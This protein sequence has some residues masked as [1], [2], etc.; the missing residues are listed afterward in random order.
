MPYEPKPF[1]SAR[2]REGYHY[3]KKD[4]FE[5]GL[6]TEAAIE[7]KTNIK[8]SLGDERYDV[9]VVGA[10]YAGL[11]AARNLVTSVGWLSHLGSPPYIAQ[12]Y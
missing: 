2:T 10:G 6:V 3:T 11:I 1:S 4:G 7:P 9:V 12:F 8:S 5:K